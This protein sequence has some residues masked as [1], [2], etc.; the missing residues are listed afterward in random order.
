MVDFDCCGDRRSD[1]DFKVFKTVLRERKC[2][3]V[4][5]KT[6]WQKCCNQK[7]RQH[8][9]GVY[10][11][12]NLGICAVSRLHCAF[13]KSSEYWQEQ[14]VGSPSLQCLEESLQ[15][16]SCQQHQVPWRSP[17][18]DSQTRGTDM[19][20]EIVNKSR[21]DDGEAYSTKNALPRCCVQCGATC[22]RIIQKLD[23]RYRFQLFTCTWEL[24][25]AFPP[26][27]WG[28]CWAREDV[29]F[30]IEEERLWLR[31]AWCERPRWITKSHTFSMWERSSAYEANR[32][33]ET[34]NSPSS[35]DSKILTITRNWTWVKK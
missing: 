13:S 28:Q 12:W 25:V 24:W 14:T 1:E 17:F 7:I 9:G 11:P 18:E 4:S 34:W 27:A 5:I 20:S 3:E 10:V 15:C 16:K 33:S 2:K 6:I 32:N 35:G 23:F 22:R 19:V 29:P 30:N 21:R 31:C 8:V 26:I